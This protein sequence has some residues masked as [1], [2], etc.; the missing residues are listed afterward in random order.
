MAKRQTVSEVVQHYI[1]DYIVEHKLRPGDQLPPEG[2]IAET[3]EV[4]RVSV[5]ES[6]KV[7]QALGIVEVRH[8]NGLFVRGLNFDALLEILS[9]SLL[10]DQSSLKELYQVRKLFETGMLP[11]VVEHIREE[12]IQACYKHLQD[13]EQNMTQGRPF[14]DQ[15]RL[16]HVTLC[17][18]IGNNLLVE[19]E[20]IFWIAYRNAVNKT[21]PDI[22]QRAYQITLDNHYK[23]LAAV[24]ARNVELAQQL[25]AD[26]FEGIKK[27]I[28]MKVEEAA[29]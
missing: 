14:R 2:D 24:E 19:L 27:R 10:F 16:F 21:F 4:S 15:D 22:A 6:V 25:M 9:Y 8:G 12:H 5:R 26:H 29:E 11:E 17:Q 28:E 7:L 13:W 18:A 20:N 23:I 3:L 1:R